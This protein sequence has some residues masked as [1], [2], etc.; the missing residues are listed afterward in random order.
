MD[1]EIKLGLLSH[2]FPGLCSKGFHYSL[3]CPPKFV[4]RTGLRE[5]SCGTGMLHERT[6]NLNFPK[7]SEKDEDINIWSR[8]RKYPM[9]RPTLHKISCY[10]R[11]N[12]KQ[13]KIF[14][15]RIS[16]DLVL[17]RKHF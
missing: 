6:F 11:K 9:L 13:S 12:S 15:L 8:E 17:Y 3:K 4:L 2:L 7:I 5:I 10:C 16:L 14:I 1:H